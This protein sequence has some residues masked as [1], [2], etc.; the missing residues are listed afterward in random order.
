MEGATSL[1]G[2]SYSGEYITLLACIGQ[3]S[4]CSISRDGVVR[5]SANVFPHYVLAGS[6][7]FDSEKD[8]VQAIEFGITDLAVLC[9]DRTAFGHVIASRLVIDAVLAEARTYGDVEAGEYPSVLYYTGKDILV[10]VE[11]SFGKVMVSHR[12]SRSPGST[13]GV[14]I[15]NVMTVRIEPK[16]PAHFSDALKTAYDLSCFFSMAAGRAQRVKRIILEVERL[17]EEHPAIFS[18]A[19]SYPLDGGGSNSM[20]PNAGDLPLDPIR[21]PEEFS[22]VL[23]NWAGR[24]GSWFPARWRYLGCISKGN[25]YD[26]DRLIAAANMFDILPSGLFPSRNE[27]SANFMEVKDSCAKAFKALPKSFE[28]ESVLN[29]L[30]RISKPTLT[31]KVLSRA[32]VVREGFGGAFSKIDHAVV[33]AVKLRN[34]FVHGSDG[35]LDLEKVEPLMPFLTDVLEFVFS[36][37]DFIDAGWDARGWIV[38]HHGFGHSF[39]RFK[40]S[41]GDQIVDL[42]R[43]TEKT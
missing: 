21:S 36:A 6:S 25:T 3:P 26:Y 29:A 41:Y 38:K 28:R 31:Q 19:P 13:K 16:S 37:S 23:A 32:A 39:A 22:C 30:G 15:K 18:V 20:R 42:L 10:D 5:Y 7:H 27:L 11:T 1:V 24:H 17:G 33:I 8:F 14:R 12:P 9:D 35:G 43:V 2:V 4:G 34:F 40:K